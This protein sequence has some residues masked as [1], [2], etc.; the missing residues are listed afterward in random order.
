MKHFFSAMYAQ[1][2]SKNNKTKVSLFDRAERYDLKSRL[3]LFLS[4]FL[5][6]P[7]NRGMKKG[8]MNSKN[9][10][11]SHAFL[12]DQFILYFTIYEMNIIYFFK[13]FNVI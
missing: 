3:W 13:N 10:I 4:P 12:L 5:F 6:P 8:K 2:L 1:N 11:L 9:R 7:K